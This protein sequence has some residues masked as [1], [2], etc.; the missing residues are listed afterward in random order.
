MA[1]RFALLGW[2]LPV[3]ES[4]QKAKL[5]YGVVSFPEFESYAKEQCHLRELL[6]QLYATDQ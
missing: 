5:P 4:M 6:Y 1:N 2:S 3:I